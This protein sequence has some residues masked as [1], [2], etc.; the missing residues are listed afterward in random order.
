MNL[1]EICGQLEAAHACVIHAI[2][3]LLV[4][5]LAAAN[6]PQHLERAAELLLSVQRSNSLRNGHERIRSM[7]SGIAL[8]A[9]TAAQLLE[10]AATSY[11]GHILSNRASDAGYTPEGAPE[12]L[13]SGVSL[14]M[15]G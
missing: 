10:S 8:Q 4:T 1:E 9:E 14:V 5:D 12:K 6:C 15:E 13:F 3:E 2:D 7:L 11:M